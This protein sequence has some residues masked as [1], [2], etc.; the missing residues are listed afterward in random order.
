MYEWT[1]HTLRRNNDGQR[2]GHEVG[3]RDEYI[4]SRSKN[5]KGLRTANMN[6]GPVCFF[7]QI[8]PKRCFA[9]H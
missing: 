3:Y 4:V 8:A 9:W 6:I 5:L 2:E 7:L 1:E